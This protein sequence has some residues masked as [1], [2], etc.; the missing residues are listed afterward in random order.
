MYQ[1]PELYAVT[2]GSTGSFFY[3]E[4][5]HRSEPLLGTIVV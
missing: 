5:E 4:L 2:S 1:Y 3:A